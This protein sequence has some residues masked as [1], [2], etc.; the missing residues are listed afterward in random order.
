[1]HPLTAAQL[2]RRAVPV[3][4]QVITPQRAL[5]RESLVRFTRGEER[6]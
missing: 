3:A 4:P 2:A 1:M 6:A 5:V